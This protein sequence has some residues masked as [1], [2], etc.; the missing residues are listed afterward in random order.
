MERERTF[1]EARMVARIA[2]SMIVSV[3]VL[4]MVSL[5]VGFGV[6]W[7]TGSVIASAV[8]GT[9]CGFAAAFAVNTLHA[10]VGRGG[11]RLRDE[12]DRSGSSANADYGRPSRQADADTNGLQK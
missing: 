5:L 2:G 12:N 3:A 10:A 4:I 7:W 9:M 11:A 1:K 8:L 6:L